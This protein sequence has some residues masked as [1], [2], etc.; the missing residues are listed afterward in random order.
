MPYVDSDSPNIRYSYL[1]LAGTIDKLVDHN[2]DY[3][4][5]LAESSLRSAKWLT[6]LQHKEAMDVQISGVFSGTAK[7][8]GITEQDVDSEQLRRGIKVEM[9]HTGNRDVAKIIALDHIAKDP[10]AYNEEIL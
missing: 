6:E 8:M 4:R 7:K 1:T 9:E 5:H 2:E 10:D 3:N